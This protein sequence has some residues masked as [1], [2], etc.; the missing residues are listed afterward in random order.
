MIAA[1]IIGAALAC[2]ISTA[3][4]AVCLTLPN[5][6][7]NGV[8]ADAALV[9]GNFNAI[10]TCINTPGTLFGNQTANIVYAGPSSGGAASPTFRSLV[11]AD[12]PNPAA[13]S[14][15]GVQSAAAQSNKWINSISTSGVPSLT[16]PATTNLSDVT[17]PT[18]WTPNDSSGASLVF[19]GVSANYQ[20][21]GSLVFAYAQLTYPA[22]GDASAA[23]IGGFPIAAANATYAKQCSVSFAN[24]IS[25]VHMSMVQNLTTAVMTAAD[26]TGA[27]NSNLSG[28]QLQFICIYPSA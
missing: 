23:I 27:A 21:V 20:K 14:L 9:M 22:T 1:R 5:T 11:G 19:T 17:T 24:T 3:A 25:A 6:L 12:L 13:A 10:A 7:L 4:N 18:S 16:Q 8:V 2:L 28:K 26:G 15:G